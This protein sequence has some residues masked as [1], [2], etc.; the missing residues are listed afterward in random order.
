MA[1]F[2][3]AQ[4]LVMKAETLGRHLAN[5]ELKAH[6]LRRLYEKVQS[7]QARAADT[8][9]SR[10]MQDE[11][12]LLKPQLALAAHREAKLKRLQEELTALIDRI[13]HDPQ[14]LKEFYNFLQSILA[15]H[16]YYGAQKEE[17]GQKMIKG[18]VK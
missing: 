11:L 2:N 17:G 14:R 4:E 3:S 8:D 15:Y 13:G 12:Q 10:Q 16:K 7:M 5:T 9:L 6:Q 18:S 1:L